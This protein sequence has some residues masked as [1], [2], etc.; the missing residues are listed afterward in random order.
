MTIKPL[1][2]LKDDT[3]VDPVQHLLEIKTWGTKWKKVINPK[4]MTGQHGNGLMRK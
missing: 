4:K 3:K 2:Y 1:E